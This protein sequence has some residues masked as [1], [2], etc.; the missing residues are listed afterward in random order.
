[1][2]FDLSVLN[3]LNNLILCESVLVLN[4]VWT[5]RLS[6]L[7]MAYAVIMSETETVYFCRLS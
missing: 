5:V 3:R 4:R 6:S 7:N 2:V 1:M